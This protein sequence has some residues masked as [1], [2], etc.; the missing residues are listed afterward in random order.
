MRMFLVLGAEAFEH[1]GVDDD[2]EL[3]VRL[4]ALPFLEDLAEFALD[5][6]AHGE[7]A[8]DLAAAFAVGAVV[9]DGLA[10]ALGVALAGHLHEAELGDGQDVGLGAVAL[11]AFLHALVDLLAVLVGLHVDEI[12]HDEAADVAEA[13]LAAD[14]LGG[15]EV[16]LED[17]GTRGPCRSCGGRC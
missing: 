17:G 3:E 7:G 9:V 5:F 2:A 12:E 6:D 14:L 8:L 10:H 1:G 11:E 4:V 16:D 13:E 15:F